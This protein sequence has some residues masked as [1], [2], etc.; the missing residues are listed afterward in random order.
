VEPAPQPAAPD[1]VRPASSHPLAPKSVKVRVGQAI[2]DWTGIDPKT[3]DFRSACVQIAKAA[4][5]EGA[6]K[7]E[8]NDEQV[9]KVLAWVEKQRADGIDFT[10]AI[11]PVTPAPVFPPAPAPSAARQRFG[12]RFT[13]VQKASGIERDVLTATLFAQSGITRPEKGKYLTDEQYDE[14][15]A[16]LDQAKVTPVEEAAQ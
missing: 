16:L 11:K 3:T 4:G 14:L 7:V 15:T 13:E 8:L 6:G 12:E 9:A 5:I 2:A 1:L 10:V